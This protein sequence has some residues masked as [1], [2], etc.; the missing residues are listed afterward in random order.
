MVLNMTARGSHSL[1]RI[2]VLWYS[3][4]MNSGITLAEHA[5]EIASKPRTLR[6]RFL[7]TGRLLVKQTYEDM[8]LSDDFGDEIAQY[9]A[10]ELKFIGRALFSIVIK[11]NP[12][13]RDFLLKRVLAINKAAKDKS[14]AI[15]KYDQT[16]KVD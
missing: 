7:V 1:Y 3:I 8:E 5:R 10:P 2:S 12:G 4:F 14:Q 11:M 15:S 13:N 6:D 9:M 16:G